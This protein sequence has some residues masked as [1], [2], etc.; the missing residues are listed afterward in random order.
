[1][2]GDDIR[3]SALFIFLNRT[4][5]NGLYR[6]NRQGRFNVPY[7]QYLNPLICDEK[8]LKA[9]STA[10]RNVEILCGDFEAT[11]EY[12]RENTLYYLDP[13]Y[14]PIT[15]TSAFTSYTKEGFSDAEQQRV[16]TFC[17]KIAQRGA[18]FIASNSDC[19]DG[20]LEKMYEPFDVRRVTM[21]R[22]INSKAESRGSISELLITNI[23]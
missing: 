22:N 17:K 1:M 23:G 3:L 21:Q 18:V 6:V 9:D 15:S 7:G 12:A 10:L 20:Y 14:R 11:E 13:P 4:A 16:A 8:T 5:F 19:G 2:R